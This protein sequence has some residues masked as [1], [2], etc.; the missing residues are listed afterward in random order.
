MHASSLFRSRSNHRDRLRT[1][2]HRPSARFARWGLFNSF[3]CLLLLAVL[4]GGLISSL[5]AVW[6]S[7]HSPLL[8][9]L[10]SE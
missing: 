10:R 5:I 7:I 3:R 1:H 6:A 8:E 4:A 9:S 2:R